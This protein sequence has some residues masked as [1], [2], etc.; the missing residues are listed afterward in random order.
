[1]FIFN[2]SGTFAWMWLIY[3]ETFNFW[4][5]FVCFLLTFYSLVMTFDKLINHKVV[6][7][8]NKQFVK[9]ISTEVNYML[10]Q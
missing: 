8:N 3:N 4:F 1:M 5:S 2:I 9:H 6:K 7:T 10:K